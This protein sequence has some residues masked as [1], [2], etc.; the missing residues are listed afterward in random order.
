[1]NSTELFTIKKA[2]QIFGSSI[3]CSDIEKQ[4]GLSL[5]DF[6]RGA[7]G[8]K[9]KSWS[10]N[11]IAQVGEQIGFL[12]KPNTP[13]AISIFVTK[14]G[15]LKTSLTLNIARMAALHNIKTC[16]VGLDMQSDITENLSDTLA[17]ENSDF[18]SA[19]K[20]L[21]SV[22][23]L[24]QVFEGSAKLR[25]TILSTDLPNLK[26]IPET[27][28]LVALDQSLM[29]KNRREYWLKENIIDELKKDFSLIIM[30]CS[31]NWNRLITNALVASDLLISPVECKINNFRNLKVFR[32]L[33]CEFQKDMQKELNHLYVPTKYSVTRKLSSEI[34]QWYVENLPNCIQTPMKESICGEEASA[35]KLSIPEF[36]AN[37]DSAFEMRSILQSIFS[38]F[39][40]LEVPFERPLSAFKKVK[41]DKQDSE[42]L[43]QSV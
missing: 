6:A 20:T 17:N 16:V 8:R 21:N 32:A 24:A 27:P 30:D 5:P 7:D 14:G 11:E 1:M 19:L 9:L 22:Q 35:L 25:D 28:E 38:N 13:R 26:F 37:S 34:C 4:I 12:K 41:D 29:N 39:L 36:Q 40:T 3:Q 2:L 10:M 15:V 33:I 42:A 31:P 43:W 18:K 23:G